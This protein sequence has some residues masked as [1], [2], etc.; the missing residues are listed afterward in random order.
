[1]GTV[2]KA[3]LRYLLRRRSLTLL[4][5]MG[6]AFGVAACLGMG[7]SAMSALASFTG[8]I[9]FLQGKSTHRIERD[10]GP[11]D[12]AILRDLMRD[13]SVQSFSPVIDR[14]LRL[15]KGSQ[16]RILGVDPFL[17]LAIRPELARASFAGDR[18]AFILDEKAVL[19][20]AGLA[21]ELNLAAGGRIKTS[22]GELTVLGTFPNPSGEPLLLMDIA[23]AQ[24]LFKVPGLI[25]AVDLVLAEEQVFISRWDEGFRIRSNRQSRET[26][27]AMLGAFRLNLEALSLMALFVA[28]FLIYNTAMFAVVSRR[29]DAGVLRSL[30]ASR[31]EVVAAF[32]AEILI[33]GGIGGALG[34]LLGYLLSRFLIEILGGTITNLYFFLRPVPMAWSFWM[35]AAGVIVGIGASLLGSLFPLIELSRTDPVKAL[36]GRSV[37]HQWGRMSKRAAAAGLLILLISAA[38]LLVPSRSIYAAFG[39]VFGILFALSLLSGFAVMLFSPLMAGFLKFLGGLPG[40]IAA[41]NIRRNLGRTA[42]AIAAFMVALSMSLG[43]SLMIGSFR[44]SLLWWMDR[45]FR[46]DL[47]ISTASEREVPEGLYHELKT[48]PG[49]DVDAYRKVQLSYRNRPM[50]AASVSAPVLQR[51]AR[52]AWLGGGGDEHWEAVKRG[53]VII[54]ESFARNFS[55]KAGDTILLDTRQGPARLRVEAVFYDYSTEH[56]LVM[57]DRNTYLRLFDDRTINSVAVFLNS[58]DPKRM[59]TLDLIRHKALQ[60]DLPVYTREQFF[61]NILAIFDSTFA[62]TRSMR[63]MAIIIAF[64]GIAGALMT[65][66]LER[67]SEFGILRA[68]GFSTGQVSLLTLLEA[69]GMGLLSFLFSIG[70]GTLFAV[71]L[72]RVINL[73]SFNWTIF[74]H[75]HLSPYLIVALTAFLASLGA[76]LYPIWMVL[77]TYPQMQ[78]RDD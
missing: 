3:F 39:A 51:H 52:F 18:L 2:T 5:L 69:F 35:P 62:I 25:D 16:I 24:E 45:Q 65:L 66:F 30:G 56:G 53:D 9:E 40:K 7:L 26:F 72:I 32:L 12:E 46:G 41:G 34:S 31:K 27:G 59:E 67:R 55:V 29:R 78:I 47:Y 6:I 43:L 37:S 58:G 22:R 13:P 73:R 71:I 21:R 17:D 42:V 61:G 74:F 11:M 54:S 63:V 77:R 48:I 57:M 70:C 15:E 8:A 38:V 44:E 14:R 64:F 4:Q 1:M 28:V 10:A 23:H 20:E 68:L 49:V 75:P 50:F 76:A 33:L 19:M 36:S 60:Y